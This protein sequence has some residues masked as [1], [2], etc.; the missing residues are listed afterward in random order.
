[1]FILNYNSIDS[2]VLY[3]TIIGMKNGGYDNLE[4][5]LIGYQLPEDLIVTPTASQQFFI[6]SAKN[7]YIRSVIVK[8]TA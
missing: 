8:A 4:Q 5:Y 7:R 2:Q 1:M 3:K 6:A